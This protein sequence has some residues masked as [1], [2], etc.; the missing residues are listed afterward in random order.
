MYHICYITMNW[1]LLSSH[2]LLIKNETW[3]IK[4]LSPNHIATKRSRNLTSD[5]KLSV[6]VLSWVMDTFSVLPLFMRNKPILICALWLSSWNMK[7]SQHDSVDESQLRLKMHGFIA[8][9]DL[10]RQRE[11]M[12]WSYMEAVEWFLELIPCLNFLFLKK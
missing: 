6:T 8:N 10:K 2:I 9:R 5:P 11:N 4:N 3:N 1:A 7:A 12:N